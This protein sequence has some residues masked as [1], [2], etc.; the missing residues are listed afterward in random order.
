MPG[1]RG[2]LDNGYSPLNM[3]PSVL[4]YRGSSITEG[5][6]VDVNTWTDEG[7]LTGGPFDL[8]YDVGAPS[9]VLGGA[10]N[11]DKSL[12]FDGASTERMTTGTTSGALTLGIHVFMVVNQ[13]SW[14]SGD[15]ILDGFATSINLRQYNTPSPN[16]TVDLAG[17]NGAATI[18]SWFIWE[19]STGTG[20]SAAFNFHIG[21]TS[22]SGNL[23]SASD[24]NGIVIATDA[25]RSASNA[26]IEVAELLV[27][28]DVLTGSELTDTRNYLA[29]KYS[30]TAKS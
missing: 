5:D 21:N 28:N 20:A 10:P 11:G 15:R 22:S 7:N 8:D 2:I 16:V 24:P 1:A 29:N 30:L 3:T 13:R 14:T 19:L 6:G 27:F 12:L 4:W 18:D 9:C 26:N 25:F 17:S 23:T